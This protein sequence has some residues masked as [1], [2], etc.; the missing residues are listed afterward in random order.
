MRDGGHWEKKEE[1]WGT[2][3]ESEVTEEPQKAGPSRP[4]GV[5]LYLEDKGVSQKVL[6]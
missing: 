2:Q 3:R 5:W 4:Y 6:I 1:K